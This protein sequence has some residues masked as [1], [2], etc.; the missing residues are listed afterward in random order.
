MSGLV[1]VFILFFIHIG[2]RRVHI[3]GMTTNPDRPWMTQQARNM[4]M[5]FDQES[6]K[7]GFLLRNHDSKFVAEFDAILET[8]GIK[9]KPI[10]VRA[11]N[12]NATAERFVQSVKGECL[13]HFL[14]LERHICD[15][16]YPNIWSIITWRVRIRD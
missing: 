3:S 15:T 11:P 8:E 7:P 13:D 12:Q 14:V 16:Y 5:I 6:V 1:D 2:S 4:A 10:G 9:I